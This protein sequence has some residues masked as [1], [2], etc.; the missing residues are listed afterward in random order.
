LSRFLSTGAANILPSP[1]VPQKKKWF[2]G[3]VNARVSSM[4]SKTS[5]LDNVPGEMSSISEQSAAKAMDSVLLVSPPSSPGFVGA[6]KSGSKFSQLFGRKTLKSN[7]SNTSYGTEILDG[8]LEQS[9]SLGSFESGTLGGVSSTFER[10]KTFSFA[11]APRTS[12][13][14]DESAKRSGLGADT[15]RRSKKEGGDQGAITAAH[16][17]QAQIDG[18]NE[19]QNQVSVMR[20]DFESRVQLLEAQIRRELV[21]KEVYLEKMKLAA[22]K[23]S[24]VV[25]VPIRASPNAMHF[26][27]CL[28]RGFKQMQAWYRE[29]PKYLGSNV[30]GEVMSNCRSC[31]YGSKVAFLYSKEFRRLRHARLTR[32]LNMETGGPRLAE[33]IRDV[34]HLDRMYGEPKEKTRRVYGEFEKV[35]EEA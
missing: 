8:K 14:T 21:A 12:K 23:N 18:I 27:Q 24:F 32:F 13:A 10:S 2:S 22:I 15:T 6:S 34:S 28:Y 1:G 30:L 20:E 16:V 33:F 29:A 35:Q 17:Q 4:K 5:P 3:G 25:S 11:P 7:Q 9:R 26:Q 31:P 19:I